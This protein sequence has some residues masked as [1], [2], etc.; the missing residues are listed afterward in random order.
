M[1]QRTRVYIYVCVCVC[2]CMCMGDNP[3]LLAL[4][5]QGI[6]IL[7]ERVDRLKRAASYDNRQ[8]NVSF[9][10]NPTCVEDR[11]SQRRPT[12]LRP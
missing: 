10:T 2:V 4:Q 12:R 11:S 1:H 6:M 5:P 7:S 9:F 3:Q 8:V